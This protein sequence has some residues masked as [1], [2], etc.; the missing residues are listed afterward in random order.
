MLC[1]STKEVNESASQ[2]FLCEADT[3]FSQDVEQ[4]GSEI[5]EL[6]VKMPK[7]TRVSVSESLA[8]RF[9][10]LFHQYEP[11]SQD[12]E[13]L[14]DRDIE[15][16][17]L[18]T[19]ERGNSE[20]EECEK[21]T[22]LGFEQNS[23]VWM[24]SYGTETYRDPYQSRKS[25]MM[26]ADD[27]TSKESTKVSSQ[28]IHVDTHFVE[29]QTR[30]VATGLVDI[31]NKVEPNEKTGG[32][33]LKEGHDASEIH[34]NTRGKA[35]WSGK[36]HCD[37]KALILSEDTE[38]K[39]PQ[40]KNRHTRSPERSNDVKGE[41]RE[42]VGQ[43][44]Y[45]RELI[46]AK[47]DQ[48]LNEKQES[49][50]AKEITN[51]DQDTNSNC[52][53]DNSEQCRSNQKEDSINTKAAPMVLSVDVSVPLP[54]QS[55]PSVVNIARD[56]KQIG[57][58]LIQEDSDSS[59][60]QGFQKVKQGGKDAIDKYT[61]MES[62]G[63]KDGHPQYKSSCEG[64][65]ESIQYAFDEGSKNTEYLKDKENIDNIITK[66]EP[67][68]KYGSSQTSVSAKGNPS[69]AQNI[70]DSNSR[71]DSVPYNKIQ[72]REAF[73]TKTSKA[74]SF[75]EIDV[76]IP[77][78]NS[79]GDD[80]RRE[81]D[82]KP[83]HTDPTT[84]QQEC[85]YVKKDGKVIIDRKALMQS[86]DLQ[87][88]QPQYQNRCE[89]GSDSSQNVIYEG[90]LNI[91]DLQDKKKIHY[92]SDKSEPHSKDGKPQ[93]STAIKADHDS[94][95][96]SDDERNNAEQYKDQQKEVPIASKA[97][98]AFSSIDADASF[99][100]QSLYSGD[101]NERGDEKKGKEVEPDDTSSTMKE[102]C[103]QTHDDGKATS[104]Y[105]KVLMQSGVVEDGHP[106]DSSSCIGG[107]ERSKNAIEEERLAR[108]DFKDK[109]KKD[110]SPTKA[111]PDF[112]EWRPYGAS[113]AKGNPNSCRDTK[114]SDGR[115]ENVEQYKMQQ[116]EESI[117]TKTVL[118][119]HIVDNSEGDD[120][121]RENIKPDPTDP[122]TLQQECQNVKKD[123]KVIIDRKALMQSEDLQDGQPQY[124]NRCEGGSDSS[125]N[126]IYEGNL[127]I[128]DLQEKKKIHYISDKSEQHSKD[129]KPQES[130][131]ARADYNSC[132][133]SDGERKN[134]E[135]YKDHQ[136]EVPIASKATLAFSSIDADASFSFQSLSSGDNS[137]RGDKKKE[138]EIGQTHVYGKA[139]PVYQNIIM[140]SEVLEDG[141]P[142]VSS[143]CKGGSERSQNAIEEERLAKEDFKDIEKKDYFPTNAEPDLGRLQDPNS[144][145]GGS[146]RRQDT[147]VTDK[148]DNNPEKAE[149]DPK[150]GKTKTSGDTKAHSYSSQETKEI[151]G[152][153]NNSEQYKTQQNEDSIANKASPTVPHMN[154]DFSV[155]LRSLFTGND[156]AKH[157]KQKGKEDKTE[158]SG[159]T[160]T[161][162]CQNM[163]E[164]GKA[165]SDEKA[166]TSLEDPEVLPTQH[167]TNLTKDPE[168]TQ[169]AR[170]KGSKHVEDSRDKQNRF[171]I[172]TKAEP[173][174]KS[175]KPQ[176]LRDAKQLSSSSQYDKHSDSGRENTEKNKNR[177]EDYSIAVEVPQ[178]IRFADVSV[179]SPSQDLSS[180]YNNAR[181]DVQ[182]GTEVKPDS[183]MQKECQKG[184]ANAKPVSDPNVLIK[185]EDLG[186]IE[187]S[188]R[189]QDAINI[190][191]FSMENLEYKQK[192]YF[193]LR[194][195]KP[196][197][198]DG[199][200][201]E[202]R[203]TVAKGESICTK[204]KNDSDGKG[205]NTEQCK[206]QQKEESITTKTV[207]TTSSAD[208]RITL[209]Y[210]TPYSDDDKVSDVRKRNEVKRDYIDSGI[211]PDCIESGIKQK[212]QK[213]K[214]IGKA[215]SDPKDLIQSEDIGDG[216]PPDQGSCAEGSDRIQEAT[217][218]GS[219]SMEDLKYKEKRDYVLEKA[220][221]DLHDEKP[222]KSRCDQVQSNSSKDTNASDGGRDNKEQRKDQQRE[223]S[224][225]IKAVPVITF[226][227]V[228]ISLP[229]QS[230]PSGDDNA[231][232]D[233]QK[234][235]DIKL[236][237]P[238][239]NR[240][241]ECQQ[242]KNDEGASSD[243]VL[244]QTE[245]IRR[246][247]AA[248]HEQL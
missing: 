216:Q 182:K 43:L 158:G 34:Y 45:K 103:Q 181:E 220:K 62:D 149:P 142:R 187:C 44:K 165:A 152:R 41:G 221:P 134:T 137:E 82:I 147:I 75:I 244:L 153:S 219:F 172:P 19:D 145:E 11:G 71:G 141:Q 30:L 26:V 202:S 233:V 196:D 157:H 194:E 210:Q 241:E 201:Q 54:F 22:L 121:W 117:A 90:N 125:Q 10:S 6:V 206:D 112:K 179:F 50:D 127:N 195:A 248:R 108:E 87:D 208:A 91:E 140:Q 192:R 139:S 29:E 144:C 177:Q 235:K 228:N 213:G 74:I 239:S 224:I 60:Q 115:R 57:K 205:Y 231:K 136:K 155:P 119:V 164:S 1:Q 107:S 69:S 28:S 59:T 24:K 246:S 67:D 104:L 3:N 226:K 193:V 106:R 81:K 85:Q 138:K 84:L 162:E 110:Y 31:R 128:E 65:S 229:F 55:H 215:V 214:G 37:K 218:E 13:I 63:F 166:L 180:G 173:D 116:T 4:G 96:K 247:P 39:Q 105:K 154:V 51:S 46:T 146:G 21:E 222:H 18:K 92:I 124:Q 167:S 223:E 234:W 191:S 199:K 100:F 73:V 217:N 98:L 190:G 80:V 36:V 66:A 175:C 171:V 52:S 148:R 99:S 150:V 204:F 35:K 156:I 131:A 169:E 126:V 8:L 114:G 38:H 102:E 170:I 20:Q 12:E 198:N 174:S 42:N 185:S 129:W 16:G 58:K 9:T 186:G 47:A 78:D 101:K 79:E 53:K 118:A 227:D 232:D 135:Q 40:D 95:P 176:Q 48:K 132:P 178:A 183:V 113:C 70:K 27:N 77:S 72:Q 237:C 197:S 64:G 160:I 209:S 89:E 238:D 211:T 17:A 23:S 61:S 245:E 7:Q 200:P 161:G 242:G 159:S 225:T 123:G 207:P 56:D 240:K 15:R 86:E 68:S 33:T 25:P 14:L 203:V 188:E 212:C 243:Q 49:K 230:L 111:K 93:D 143:R 151:D 32:R 168:E 76:S 122:T 184:K 163:Q 109:E 120:V 2:R 5:K 189:I 94:S 97:T 88:G 130:S 83:D 133:N 236:H